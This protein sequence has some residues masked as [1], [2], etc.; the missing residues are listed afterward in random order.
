M[1][2]LDFDKIITNLRTIK[3]YKFLCKFCLKHLKVYKR[4]F[5]NIDFS[6]KGM[7]YNLI[8]LFLFLKGLAAFVST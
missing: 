7:I 8:C 3:D 2:S 5:M 1:I 4:Y 6:T